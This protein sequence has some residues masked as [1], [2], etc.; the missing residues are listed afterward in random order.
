MRHYIYLCFIFSDFNEYSVYSAFIART[1]QCFDELN[2]SLLSEML[3]ITQ[4]TPVTIVCE[5]KECHMF[6]TLTTSFLFTIDEL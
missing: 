2:P 1:T 5:M 3:P 4:L 6:V